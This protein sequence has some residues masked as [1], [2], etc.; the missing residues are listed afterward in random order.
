MLA[1]MRS[2]D[3]YRY[4]DARAET[5]DSIRLVYSVKKVSKHP[6]RKDRIG[7]SL[8]LSGALACLIFVAIAVHGRSFFYGEHVRRLSNAARDFACYFDKVPTV[9][10]L[11]S[12][13][14]IATSDPQMYKTFRSDGVLSWSLTPNSDF[15][16]SRS[17][18]M[19]FIW[20]DHWIHRKDTV[21]LSLTASNCNESTK[22][23]VS[24]LLHLSR[25]SR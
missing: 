20:N 13:L 19:D 17:F 4:D 11:D 7:L 14:E 18:S 10:E 15:R 24:D 9:Q 25:P 22:I 3:I 12:A 8:L 6:V 2:V 23:R 16:T 21:T 1:L 5:R